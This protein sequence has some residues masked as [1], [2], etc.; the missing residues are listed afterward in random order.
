MSD[1]KL[2]LDGTVE[3]THVVEHH[4][5]EFPD[6]ANQVAYRNVPLGGAEDLPGI[7][8]ENAQLNAD[9]GPL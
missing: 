7:G 6:S 1:R 9:N 2:T 4:G 3:P 5:C 8:I